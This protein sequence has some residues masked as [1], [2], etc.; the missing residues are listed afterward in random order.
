MMTEEH[1][2]SRIR[3]ALNQQLNDI[4]PTALRRMEA[5]RH[6]ALS[7]QKQSIPVAML[8]STGHTG[9]M[10]GL[11][12]H[13]SQHRLRERLRHLLAIGALLLGMAIAAYW[14]AND[15]IEEIV[16][17]D[18]ALLTDDLPPEAFIDKGFSTWLLD[19]SSEE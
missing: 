17:V 19:D 9:S 8:A 16:D 14:Q 5:A 13:A 6:H 4:P 3:Q 10:H 18:S 7:R 12:E 11:N 2:A 15:Y 1:T